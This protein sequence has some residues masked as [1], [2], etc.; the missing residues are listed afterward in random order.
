MS[1]VS[2]VKSTMDIE[3]PDIPV[4]VQCSMG[5]GHGVNFVQGRLE[6]DS[7]RGCFFSARSVGDFGCKLLQQ[8]DNVFALNL[9]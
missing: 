1:V 7:V 5:Y 8:Q 9:P 4:D 2:I 3:S 6:T